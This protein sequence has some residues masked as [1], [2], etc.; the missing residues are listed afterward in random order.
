MSLPLISFDRGDAELPESWDA[1]SAPLAGLALKMGVM[2]LIAPALWFIICLMNGWRA[3]HAPGWL[4]YVI[5]CAVPV[6]IT[7]VLSAAALRE[8]RNPLVPLKGI[9]RI[10]TAVLFAVIS[11]VFWLLVNWLAGTIG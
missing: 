10:R 11:P 4:G 8:L 1:A 3:M 2:G 5:S 6:A 7:L 9:E